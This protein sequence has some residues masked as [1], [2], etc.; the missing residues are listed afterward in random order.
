MAAPT[1]KTIRHLRGV[2]IFQDEPVGRFE[3]E[4][5]RFNLIY[6]F[7]G[8]GKTTLA[9][10]LDSI[11]ENGVSD[12]LESGCS[13]SFELSDG[14]KPGSE[15]PECASARYIAVFNEDYISKSLFWTEGTAEPIVYIGEEQADLAKEIEGLERKEEEA[16][17]EETLK[18]S[19]W[20]SAE[21]LA[22]E[23]A[24]EIG[25]L[26]AAE[27]NLGRKYNAANVRLDYEERDFSPEDKLDE[28]SQIKAKETINQTTLPSEIEV[29]L[30]KPE[31][32]PV[33]EAV[34][35]ACSFSVVSITID[36]LERR[37][38]ALQW[39]GVGIDLHD[40]EEE[41]L[42]CGNALTD[43]RKE[44]LKLALSDSYAQFHSLVDEAKVAVR[45]AKKTNA[46]IRQE[47]NLMGEPLPANASTIKFA[48]N[49]LIET[50][51]KLDRL[52]GD[53]GK[54][55]DQKLSNPESAYEVESDIT[56]QSV[57]AVTTAINKLDTAITQNNEAISNFENERNAARSLLKAHHLADHQSRFNSA[58]AGNLEAKRT[59]DAAKAALTAV[60][61]E[62]SKKR[63]QLR[64]HS[65]AAAEM[66]KLL[67]GYLG[68][69]HIKL[70]A[71]DQGYQVSRR[72]SLEPK[73]LSEGE[74]TAIAFCHFLATLKSEGRNPNEFIVVLD[75][76]I[77]S[78]D[79]RAMTHAVSMVKN[80]FSDSNQVFILTH[81]LEFMREIKK[82]LGK[83][84][85]EENSSFLFIEC[86]VSSEDRFS[87]I[88][89][90]PKL[91]RE[92][93]SEY[94]YL[95]SLIKLLAESPKDHET[96]AYLMPN[97]IR[98]VLDIFLAFKVPGG[99][100][101]GAKIAKITA[102]HDNLDANRVLA[103]EHLAQLESHSESLGDL[104]SFSAYTLE[105]ISEA[106]QTLMDLIETLD[107]AHKKAMD[108]LCK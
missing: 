1:I 7:N 37:K 47:L 85:K 78:L 95:Y 9:R 42:F 8:S 16:V 89:R 34:T 56:T 21:R 72:G 17:A 71:N 29:S 66:N 105:Q 55:L 104:I 91:L 82:W 19:E 61:A 62:L 10:L 3:Q 26:V 106:S 25:S 74:R 22:A 68:H 2:G 100:G 40:Q 41:C 38:D 23:I 51:E 88:V 53:W 98:K 49:T 11:S 46:R 80:Y 24:K 59:S 77:S 103:M 79:A 70:V 65:A 4:F 36:S 69:D 45:D 83:G 102:D 58:V 27:L 12:K 39:V 93:E 43:T 52:L 48:R 81:N 20:S 30:K 108:S 97:A 67:L 15:D 5:A 63:D 44:N 75:D 64:S 107:P 92:Y 33:G 50:T 31:L 57:E 84:K 60:R 73:P 90:M 76:P 96:F 13:F 32:E 87:R 14:S 28:A 18:A 101:L 86:H 35:K 94:H 6:G 99:M 54:A